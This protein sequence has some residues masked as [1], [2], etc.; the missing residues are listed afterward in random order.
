[1]KFYLQFIYNS[2]IGMITDCYYNLNYWP[3]SWVHILFLCRMGLLALLFKR[4]CRYSTPLPECFPHRAINSQPSTFLPGKSEMEQLTASSFFIP[5]PQK[6][7][8]VASIR[9]L[10]EFNR[11]ALKLKTWLNFA[12]YSSFITGMLL[13]WFHMAHLVLSSSLLRILAQKSS[14]QTCNS[15]AIWVSPISCAL[16]YW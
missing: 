6:V 13:N 3:P 11:A 8:V 9:L 15:P 2:Y 14:W 12:S 10:S 1:M 16:V 4:E 5:I 7:S